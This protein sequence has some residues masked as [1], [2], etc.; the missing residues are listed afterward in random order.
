MVDIA[1]C[2]GHFIHQVILSIPRTVAVVATQP[3]ALV[4]HP[5]S[6]LT[7]LSVESGTGPSPNR[8][9]SLHPTL[10]NGD[11][12]IGAG[13][14]F[15]EDQKKRSPSVPGAFAINTEGNNG[16]IR[17]SRDRQCQEAATTWTKV[18]HNERQ[19]GVR[20]FCGKISNNSHLFRIDIAAAIVPRQ[21]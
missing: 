6:R 2:L 4:C 21:K 1:F 8:N 11:V 7:V 19:E 9:S 16:Y 13:M 20:T 3:C 18:R 15:V 14:V 5:D 12:S 17:Y 10:P